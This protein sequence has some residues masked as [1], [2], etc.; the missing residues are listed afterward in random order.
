MDNDDHVPFSLDQNRYDQSTYYGRWRQFMDM[1]SPRGLLLT[2]EKIHHAKKVL[3]SYR[4]GALMKD[5]LSDAEL[6]QAKRVCD[7]SMHPQTGEIISPI[8]RL[9]AFT[10]VNIPICAGMLLAPPTIINT[11]FWQWV[12]QSYNAGF[13]Y[14]NRNASGEQATTDILKSYLTATIVSCSSAI[15]LGKLAEKGKWSS[16]ARTLI[17]TMVPFVA[18]ASAG[19][20]NAVSIR[21]NELSEGIDI[22]DSDGNMHGRSIQAARQSLTQVALTRVA[23][24]VPI[25][26]LPPYIFQC[27]KRVKIMPS[28]KY[29]KL[30]TELMVVTLCLWGALPAAVAIFPLK[31]SINADNIEEKYRNI[32]S[33]DGKRI[34]T[35]Y[36]SKGI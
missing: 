13:N 10:P 17:R 18:V 26:L 5:S 3:D 25:L 19:A 22:M 20:F 35:F 23:I 8:F 36:Y 7:S 28:T 11:I 4:S 15:G 30:I 31:G 12:N 9:S 14:A 16:T 6:W 34:E 33:P 24:P 2:S 21:Y 27:M 1:V 29:I 32:R